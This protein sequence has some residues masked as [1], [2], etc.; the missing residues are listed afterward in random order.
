MCVLFVEM[1]EELRITAF[2]AAAIALITATAGAI[3]A[4]AAIFLFIAERFQDS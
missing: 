2:V 3:M 4:D 1:S